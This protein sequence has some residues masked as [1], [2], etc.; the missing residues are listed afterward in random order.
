MTDK[1]IYLLIGPKGSGKS[2]IGTLFEKHFGIKFVRVENWV[3]TIRENRKIDDESYIKEVFNI[4]E[5]GIRLEISEVNNLVFESTGISEYFDEMISLLRKDFKI[6]TIN[7]NTDPTICLIR[8]K[9]RDSS[10]HINVSDEEVIEINKKVSEK[11]ML[12][13][14]MIVNNDKVENQLFADIKRI[15][16][17]T[18]T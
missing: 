4:I 5:K 6:I 3:K 17:N 18:T 7:I 8:V 1:V 16:E 2:Y 10:I 9:S 11:R 13:D 15:L 12:S 14:F